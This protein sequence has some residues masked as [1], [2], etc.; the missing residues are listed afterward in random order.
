M[1]N[2]RSC[3]NCGR[4]YDTLDWDEP[5][6]PFCGTQ[7]K[8]IGSEATSV[9]ADIVS[10][11]ITWPPGELRAKVFVASSYMEAQI[12][13]AQLESAG[14]PVFLAGHSIG[15]IYG[16]TVGPMAEVTVFVPQSRAQ[17]AVQILNS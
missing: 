3:P 1:V 17:E 4:I 9:L 15:S 8:D 14:V 6:C 2:E 13:K 16:L 5:D 12:A 11:Q 7:L 10:M